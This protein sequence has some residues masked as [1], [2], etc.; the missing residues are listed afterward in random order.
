VRY[1]GSGGSERARVAG[2]RKLKRVLL[3][4]GLDDVTAE[5]DVEALHDGRVLVLVSLS[6]VGA[7]RVIE[8]LDAFGV[9]AAVLGPRGRTRP[10][11]VR[12]S[13]GIENVA[14]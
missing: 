13:T 3:D 10:R 4:A 14:V 11:A 1:A 12:R 5:R 2:H 8:L 9:A 6:A 7:D